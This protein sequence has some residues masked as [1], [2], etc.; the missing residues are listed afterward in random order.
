VS[1]GVAVVDS[2]Q[3]PPA[4]FRL[5][6]VAQLKSDTSRVIQSIAVIRIERQRR[7]VVRQC[8]R[9]ITGDAQPCCLLIDPP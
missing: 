4:R 3:S 6:K 7:I 5:G 9:H 8:R 2:K 1:A